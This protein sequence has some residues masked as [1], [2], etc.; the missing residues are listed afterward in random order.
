MA[1]SKTFLEEHPELIP[2]LQVYIALRFLEIGL[3]VFKEVAL[4]NENQ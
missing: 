4:E 2:V 1:D 3:K